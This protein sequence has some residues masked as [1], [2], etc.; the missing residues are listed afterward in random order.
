MS[1]KIVLS[2]ANPVVSY[3]LVPVSFIVAFFFRYKYP[4][5]LLFYHS[6]IILSYGARHGVLNSYIKLAGKAHFIWRRGKQKKLK[7]DLCELKTFNC[8]EP[9]VS[10][11]WKR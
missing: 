3:R 11:R 2:Y 4:R 1:Y 6:Y 8:D 10:A 5:T 7:M 9:A